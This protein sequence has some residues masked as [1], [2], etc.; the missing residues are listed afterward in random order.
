MLTAGIVGLPNVGKS[1][2]FNALTRSHQAPVA[3]YPFCTIDPNVGVIE[4]P[5]ERLDRLVPIYGAA[6]KIPAAIEFFDIAGLV[7]GAS[8]GEGLGNQFLAQIRRVDAIVEVVRGF[9]QQDVA[10]VEGCLDPIR[11]IETI[12]T[13]LALADLQTVQRRKDKI[14]KLAQAGDKTARSEMEILD[15]L[16]AALD[17]KRTVRGLELA[18]GER[19][20][21]DE[22]FLLTAKPVI[23]LTNVTEAELGAASAVA[24]KVAEYAATEKAAAVAVCA[25]LEAQLADLEIDEAAE[26]LS[27][28]GVESTGT[29]ELIGA[30]YRILGLITFFTGNEKEIRARAVRRGTTALQAAGH[31]HSDIERGF[32]A[33]EVLGFDVLVQEES[34]HHAREDGRLRREGKQYEV[35]DGDVIF[36]RFQ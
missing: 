19:T 17:E 7:R 23:Y 14:F 33:A 5:D 27:S 4:V 9:E 34:I 18:E 30:T 1:T 35:Q 21:A 12:R 26:Y 3:S 2:L 13:E 11:D 36:F 31:V 32:I 6:K 29:S 20:L 24:D 10:H 25:E 22:L 8:R 28:L 16:E 15:K